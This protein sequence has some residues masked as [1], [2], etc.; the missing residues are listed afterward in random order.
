MVRAVWYAR[1]FQLSNLDTVGEHV[2]SAKQEPFFQNLRKSE[3]KVE[4]Y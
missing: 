1:C 2:H 3:K 4:D